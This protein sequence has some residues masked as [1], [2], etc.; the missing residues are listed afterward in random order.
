MLIPKPY[1]LAKINLEILYKI[2]NQIITNIDLE[3][4][5]KFLILLNP[6]LKKLSVEKIN[7][8]SNESI[9]NRKI[10]EIELTKFIYINKENLG[11]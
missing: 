11:K 3:N 1:V 9:K 4:E 2:N 7:E 5:K 6:N 10:K 8:I